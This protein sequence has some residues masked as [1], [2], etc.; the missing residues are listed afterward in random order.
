MVLAQRSRCA[1]A[2]L[3]LTVTL[4]V[5]AGGGYD[6]WSR[7]G[8]AVAAGVALAVARPPL[9]LWREPLPAILGAL[10]VL[11]RVSATWTVGLTGEAR[12][13]GLVTAAYAAVA[14]VAAHVARSPRGL[15]TLA[16]GVAVL[17]GATALAGLAAAALGSTP[18][19]IAL[20]GEWRPA[21]PF[22]YPPAL[23]LLQ[24][25]ALGV[26]IAG[27]QQRSRPVAGAAAA[28]MAC[29]G[30]VLVL[31]ESRTALA[32]AVAVAGWALV[33]PHPGAGRRGM[34]AAI[35]VAVAAGGAMA[36]AAR[37][38][39]GPAQLA[40]D[41]AVVA[42]LGASWPAL[43]PRGGGGRPAPRRALAGVAA[44]A[45]AAGLLAFGTGGDLLHGRGSTWEAAIETFAERPLHGA[46]ADSFLSASVP[47][48]DGRGIAFAHDLP[49]EIAAELGIP[50][51]LLV[52]ALY[53]A[54]ALLLWRA[55]RTRAVWLLGPAVAAFLLAGLVDWPWHLAGAGAVWALA[56]GAVAG[57]TL[58][59]DVIACQ[60]NG[61]VT[62]A[63]DRAGPGERSRHLPPLF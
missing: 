51:L 61:E 18:Y 3:L 22:E 38:G 24:V 55:R 39:T 62:P 5:F 63:A 26:L 48:Q 50:G 16:A 12:R 17:A 6:A 47:H 58:P 40:L 53:G 21:G 31:A 44:A 8:F 15:R 36:V 30:G 14:V 56:A 19:A 34:A 45:V 37:L 23:A 2:A 20:G 60:A 46:G 49:L 11:G 4:A 35:G 32:L 27:M 43:R 9:R 7:V 57:A 42:L 25:S 54:A 33:R 13:W 41:L 59:A 28:A 29:A 52:L 1:P 10:G